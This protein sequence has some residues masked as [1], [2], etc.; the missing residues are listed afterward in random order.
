MKKLSS[1]IMAIIAASAISACGGDD[2][3]VSDDLV[4]SSLNVASGD[5]DEETLSNAK[6]FCEQIKTIMDAETNKIKDGFS[7]L[8]GSVAS[9]SFVISEAGVTLSE[10]AT[11]E[12]VNAALSDFEDADFTD[13]CNTWKSIFDG[14]TDFEGNTIEDGEAQEID[15]GD[16]LPEFN[17]EE[18]VDDEDYKNFVENCGATTGELTACVEDAFSSITSPF[19]NAQCSSVKGFFTSDAAKNFE[20][21]AKAADSGQEIDPPESCVKIE[22]KCSSF[23]GVFDAGKI[24]ANAANGGDDA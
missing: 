20:E 9:V 22:E 10:D 8:I 5:A 3:D 13:T 24:A 16:T 1:V 14:E 19:E 18:I 15:F 4:V 12:E 6:S 2:N 23:E 7:T 21:F 17:C 11:F